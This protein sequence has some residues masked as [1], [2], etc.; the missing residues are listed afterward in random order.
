MKLRQT[1]HNIRIARDAAGEVLVL[2]PETFLNNFSGGNLMLVVTDLVPS[3]GES[4]PKDK[5][6]GEVIILNSPLLEI[7]FVQEVQGEVS[8]LE[9]NGLTDR[10]IFRISDQAPS[11]GDECVFFDVLE[12]SWSTDGADLLTDSESL[13]SGTDGTWCAVSHTSV[14]AIAQTIP[15]ETSIRAIPIDFNSYIISVFMVGVGYL[16]LIP[17][18]CLVLLRRFHPPSVGEA[19]LACKSHSRPISFTLS[20]V[21][22]EKEDGAKERKVLV[23]WDVSPE[24]VL[25]ELDDLQLRHVSTQLSTKPRE[26]LHVKSVKSEASNFSRSATEL[27]RMDTEPEPPDDEVPCDQNSLV[28]CNIDDLLPPLPSEAFRNGEMVLY[29]SRS[30]QQCIAAV[31]VGKGT[32]CS[33]ESSETWPTY[34][35]RVGRHQQL[36]CQVP[37]SS[38]RPCPC[39]GEMVLAWTSGSWMP[40]RFGTSYGYIGIGQVVLEDP[41]SNQ[42]SLLQVPLHFIRR[43]FFKGQHCHVY[44]GR[45][46]GWADGTIEED[47]VDRVDIDALARCH[48]D[49]S[50]LPDSGGSDSAHFAQVLVSIDCATTVFVP[51]FCIRSADLSL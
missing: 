46:I 39:P 15:F 17:A 8:I 7:S 12:D 6:V 38:L 22:T 36:R 42:A 30:L 44:R 32:F 20:K 50:S 43:R 27:S 49:E 25:P 28:S 24:N 4:L 47:K 51:I 40:A 21:V 1:D 31:I 29:W 13:E 3:V 41:T 45:D 19:T 48:E 11:P 26:V 23:K 2:L 9:V 33:D 14:F 18:G 10:M 16:I 35:C 37:L 5:G 34:D